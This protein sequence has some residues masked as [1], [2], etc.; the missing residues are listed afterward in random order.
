MDC[1][2]GWAI[3]FWIRFCFVIIYYYLLFIFYFILFE[4][5][6]FFGKEKEV[7]YSHIHFDWNRFFL[8]NQKKKLLK[9]FILLL[10]RYFLFLK[11]KI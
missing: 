11:N 5:Y 7:N 3:L 10:K 2:R 1:L 6:L 8:E 4:F 9:V